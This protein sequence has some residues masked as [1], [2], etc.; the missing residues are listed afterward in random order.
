MDII[1]RQQINLKVG[2]P[3][4]L[5]TGNLRTATI[6]IADMIEVDA[7]VTVVSEVVVVAVVEIATTDLRLL[8]IIHLKAIAD[9]PMTTTVDDN[10]LDEVMA[11]RIDSKHIV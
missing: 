9:R 4:I 1:T 5:K 3:E 10:T 8:A 7:E 11:T 6:I 2:R